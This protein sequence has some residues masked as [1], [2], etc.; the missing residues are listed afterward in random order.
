[1]SPPPCYLSDLTLNL[2]EPAGL[3]SPAAADPE[4]PEAGPPATTVPPSAAAA[5]ERFPS[6][7]PAPVF[8][9][10]GSGSPWIFSKTGCPKN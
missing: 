2:C 7:E 10:D 6:T 4:L 1:M 3:P 9:E 5:T 8:T